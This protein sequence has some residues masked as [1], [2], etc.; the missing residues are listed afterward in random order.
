MPS[1]SVLLPAALVAF[2]GFAMSLAAQCT[3]TWASGGPQAQLSGSGRCTTQW[4][5]DGAGPAGLQLVVGGSV[6]KGGSA[7]IDQL[8]MVWD[9]GQWQAL[10]PGPGT[11]P[12]GTAVVN[13]LTVWNGLLVAGGTFT[14]G[15]VDHVALWNG[16]SWQGLGS[17][18]PIGVQHLTVWNGLLVAVSQSGGVPNIRTWNGVSWSTLPLPPNLMF[19]NAVVSYQGLLCVAGAENSPTQGVL[20]RWNGSA[21]LP[22]IFAQTG[23]NCLAVRPSLA[24]GGVD[25]LY[26]AGPFAS[27]GGTTA[28]RIAATTGGT[29]FAW[30]QVGG[31]LPASCTALHVRNVGLLG[32]AIVAVV[33]NASTPVL[34]LSSGTFVAMGTAPLNSLAYYNGAYHGTQ[35]ASGDDACQRWDGT[36]WAP[37][38]GP[39]MLGEVRALCRSGSDMIVGGTFAAIS[40]T[41]MNGIARWDGA[42]FTPLG[43]GLVGGSVDALLTLGNGEFVAGG[44]FLGAGF[45]SPCIARWNGSAWQGLGTGTNGPVLALCSLPNGD[46]VAGGNFTTAG[47]VPCS[48]IARWDGVAWSPI[49]S[50]MNGTVNALAVRSDGTLFA[51]GAFTSAGGIGAS[52]IAQWNGTTWL[53]VGAGT[54]GDVLGLAVRANDDVVA[55]GAFTSAG[56]L[57]ADR[58]A[59]WTGVAWTSMGTTGVDPGPARAVFALPNGDIVAGRGFG[60]T[61]TTPDDG[62]ARWN[63][64]S[65][66]RLGVGMQEYFATVSVA[67]RALAMRADGALLVG[68][69]FSAAGGTTSKSLAVLQSTCPATATSYGSGCSSVAGPLD[70]TADTLPW[71]GAVFR[72]TT[73]GMAP[74]SLGI[75]VTGF[76]SLSIPLPTLLAEGQ[77]GCTLLAA[78]D[79]TLLLTPGPG[80]ARSAIGLANS[81][82]LLG[83]QFFQQTIPLEFDLA[84]AIAAVRGSNALALTIGTF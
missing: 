30:S 39:G 43:A 61:S 77:P 81:P 46:L 71:L 10:G 78:P 27:I 63:G 57:P 26:A 36:Q 19:P 56:G 40:G 68:G 4:D 8:V 52:R 80:T 65:W 44:Q 41:T 33:A 64:T 75:G 37:L 29:S 20:E 67:V 83:G 72:T 6:L 79:I 50:G 5:P 51:A 55:V 70:L 1:P 59:R 32:V 53:N 74:G 34:Q 42:A 62:I 38:R 9:G 17:G 28:S 84:G 23:I 45:G 13:A 76:A 18:F 11:N 21:W 7:P 12:A 16:A 82:A 3:T 73:T 2:A 35:L 48:R 58:I 22:S 69:T 31:G 15:G 54:N 25:T 49:G 24:F 60:V 14:G 66:S 47:G